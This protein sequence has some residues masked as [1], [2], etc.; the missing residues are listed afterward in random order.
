MLQP[1]CLCCTGAFRDR[2]KC[3]ILRKVHI[4]VVVAA[5]QRATARIEVL[6]HKHWVLVK[7]MAISAHAWNAFRRQRAKKLCSW[8]SATTF[9]RV[10][11]H[12]D[13][14]GVAGHARVDSKSGDAVD[15][16]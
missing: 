12:I 1:H 5:S 4:L 3:G 2:A 10:P 8:H 15:V 14:I 7:R 9:S 13:V 16:S 11:E 6:V